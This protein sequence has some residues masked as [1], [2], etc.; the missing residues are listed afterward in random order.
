MH[1]RRE[2]A[3]AASNALCQVSARTHQARG[4]TPPAL[5]MLFRGRLLSYFYS[6]RR[7]PGP[8]YLFPTEICVP[9][10]QIIEYG[11]RILSKPLLTT[12]DPRCP[13]S[14]LDDH[15][16]TLLRPDFQLKIPNS[17]SFYSLSGPSPFYS[18]CRNT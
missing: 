11:R 7:I 12:T 8:P 13:A 4:L 5:G 17:G 16:S 15:K 10:S 2:T 14:S 1:P 3:Y 6:Y 18:V 9:N